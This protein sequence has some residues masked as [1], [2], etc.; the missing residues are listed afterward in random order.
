[1]VP[2]YDFIRAIADH[3]VGIG[4]PRIGL[5]FDELTRHGIIAMEGRQVEKIWRRFFQ[6]DDQGLV[7]DGFDAD[8]IG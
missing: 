2:G 5:G 6:M 7:I 1:M 3:A 8:F 4:S